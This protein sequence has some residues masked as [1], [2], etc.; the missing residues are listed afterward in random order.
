MSAKDDYGKSKI[1][2]DKILLKS[3]KTIIIR[4]STIGHE[5]KTKRGLLEW[6]LSCNKICYGYKKAFFLD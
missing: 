2:S 6:F 5:I 4:T 3:K 1:I